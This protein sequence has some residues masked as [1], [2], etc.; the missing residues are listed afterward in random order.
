V[1]GEVQVM[2]GIR[3]SPATEGE[4]AVGIEVSD[5]ERSIGCWP[6]L[7]PPAAP[8]SGDAILG[9]SVCARLV[10]FG[11][12]EFE[13]QV[14]T[15]QG[16]LPSSFDAIRLQTRPEQIRLRSAGTLEHHDCWRPR[17]PM[18]EVPGDAYTSVARAS[19]PHQPDEEWRARGREVIV[20]E[21]GAG[22]DE[23]DA[24]AES[25]DH[26][27][28]HRPEVDGPAE[29]ETLER[30]WK[31]ARLHGLVLELEAALRP[32]SLPLLLWAGFRG[33]LVY[34]EP[35]SWAAVERAAPELP[36]GI[37]APLLVVDPALSGRGNAQAEVEP[38]PETIAA[39]LDETPSLHLVLSAG[40]AERARA[41]SERYPT[42]VLI[43][44]SGESADEPLLEEATENL[45]YLT[46][47][48]S[49]MW[50]RGTSGKSASELGRWT[51]EAAA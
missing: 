33:V 40:S 32:K 23:L 21:E 26:L 16:S 24:A 41:L 34:L 15:W 27:V 47:R 4:P 37:R 44:G 50:F 19:P 12:S 9:M 25:K 29:I 17:P 2:A 46:E 28:V 30:D 22:P 42:R 7:P 51:P 1:G 13:L 20:E 11:P 49:L 43:G 6:W 39:A 48:T 14:W 18:V 5:G 35:D 10:A 38:P 36:A 45:R 8:G 31:E 3:P